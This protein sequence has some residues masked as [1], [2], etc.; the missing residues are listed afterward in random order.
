MVT[1]VQPLGD[2]AAIGTRLSWP[3]VTPPGGS[4]LWLD[5]VTTGAAHQS[6]KV[7][8]LPDQGLSWAMLYETGANHWL[9]LDWDAARLPYLGIWVDEGHYNPALTVALEPSNGYYDSLVWAWENQRVPMV[10]PGETLAWSLTSTVG[11]SM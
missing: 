9:R 10:N 11:Q 8:T 1:A 5:R 2:W 7:Y 3:T 6:R 4:T